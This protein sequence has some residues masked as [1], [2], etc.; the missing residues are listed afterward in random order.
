MSEQSHPDASSI[1]A[2]SR[3]PTR[4]KLQAVDWKKNEEWAAQANKLL[5][6]YREKK[7]MMAAMLGPRGTGKT[8]AAVELIR[9]SAHLGRTASYCLAMDFFAKVKA[10]YG[11]AGAG[12]ETSVIND[13]C[14]T[15]LLVVDEIQV[16][17]DSQWENNLLTYLVDRRYGQMLAT[18]FIGNLTLAEFSACVGDSIHS[19]LSETGGII[20]FN[21]KSWRAK[22]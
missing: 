19:R 16:R 4:H 5:N 22:A 1:W 10:T 8:Q 18:V 3:L 21:G 15:H 14:R 2:S 12:T 17:S 11:N 9:L 20:E 6:T 7:D 13:F